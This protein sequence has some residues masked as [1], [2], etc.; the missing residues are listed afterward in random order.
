MSEESSNNFNVSDS[1]ASRLNQMIGEESVSSFSKRCGIS[2]SLIRKYL[3]GSQPSAQN[4]VLISKATGCT[5]DWLAA[6][7]PP[8]F[9]SDFT[10]GNIENNE[11]DSDEIWILKTYREANVDQKHAVKMLLKA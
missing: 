10:S 1:I 5:I 3:N 9:R 11:V 7:T 4:L 6:G 8:T 2:E